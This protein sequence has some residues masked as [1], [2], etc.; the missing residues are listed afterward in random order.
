[1]RYPASEKA[2]IIQLVDGSHRRADLDLRGADAAC[3]AVDYENLARFEGT[4][5]EHV[6]HCC[7]LSSLPP[8]LPDRNF[9][10]VPINCD[11]MAQ[12]DDR[13][14]LTVGA[15]GSP[16]RRNIEEAMDATTDFTSVADVK[17]LRVD[18]RMGARFRSGNNKAGTGASC[19]P[20][21]RFMT[22]DYEP[23]RLTRRIFGE[24]STSVGMF[25]SERIA[26]AMNCMW[27]GA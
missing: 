13:S 25:H 26:P 24:F 16:I 27:I 3:T 12:P 8:G 6:G 5:L 18:A 7:P 22:P 9:H 20:R 19:P 1:M 21:P 11:P 23:R 14:C 17:L 4:A 2:E 15:I 10:T